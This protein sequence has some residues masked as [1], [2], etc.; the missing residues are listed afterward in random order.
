[1]GVHARRTG[2]AFRSAVRPDG[3]QPKQQPPPPGWEQGTWTHHGGPTPSEG[4]G[5]WLLVGIGVFVVVIIAAAVVVLL[6]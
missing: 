2:S 5:R 6:A 4:N 3:V 1:M